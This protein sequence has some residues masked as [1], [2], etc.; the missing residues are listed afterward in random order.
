MKLVV[1][2]RIR[3]RLESS[4]KSSKFHLGMML[5]SSTIDGFPVDEVRCMYLSVTPRLDAHF[6]GENRVN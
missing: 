5:H 4:G 2:Q 3:S 1:P 6:D